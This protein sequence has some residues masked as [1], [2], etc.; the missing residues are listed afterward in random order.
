MLHTRI[1]EVV[2]CLPLLSWMHFGMR[3]GCLVHETLAVL[4]G[5]WL[6]ETVDY[7]SCIE[8]ARSV[9]SRSFANNPC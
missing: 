2:S 3:F 1:S 8:A 9:V 4:R 6:G 7:V 5:S